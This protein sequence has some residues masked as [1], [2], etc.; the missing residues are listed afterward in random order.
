[1][2][3]DPVGTVGWLLHSVVNNLTRRDFMHH[4]YTAS[5]SSNLQSPRRQSP[6]LQSPRRQLHRLPA[7]LMTLFKVFLLALNTDGIKTAFNK[8]H[9]AY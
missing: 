6:R 2:A 7:S 3:S 9:I 8:S 1:M 5:M 4:W